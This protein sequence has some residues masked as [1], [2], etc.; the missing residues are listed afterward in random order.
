MLEKVV[1]ENKNDYTKKQHYSN[2]NIHRIKAQNHTANEQ[3]YNCD[4]RETK[5]PVRMVLKMSFGI[6][7][8]K[9]FFINDNR[10]ATYQKTPD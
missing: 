7:N 3:H 8:P 1:T 2:R 5:H 6:F 4:K 10:Y 9:N